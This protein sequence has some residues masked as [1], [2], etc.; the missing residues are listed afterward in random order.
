MNT[1]RWLIDSF[2]NLGMG[3]CDQGNPLNLNLPPLPLVNQVGGL[4]SGLPQLLAKIPGLLNVNLVGVLGGGGRDAPESGDGNG[5]APAPGGG[6]LAPLGGLGGIGGAG[7]LDKLGDVTKGGLGGLLH[8]VGPGAGTGSGSDPSSSPTSGANTGNDRATP[9]SPASQDQNAVPGIDEGLLGLHLPAQLLGLIHPST[10]AA[11]ASPAPVTPGAQQGAHSHAEPNT[12]PGQGFPL[13]SD[14]LSQPVSQP[15]QSAIWSCDER[16]NMGAS[17]TNPD[18][19]EL[20]SCDVDWKA[21][22]HEEENK[23]MTC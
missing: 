4:L 17:W 3:Q 11:P 16:G 15:A 8:I 13:D 7:G 19:C 23:D 21:A 14:R 2:A 18:G 10:P 6:L 22:G 1:F 12:N 20:F 9:S 5:G